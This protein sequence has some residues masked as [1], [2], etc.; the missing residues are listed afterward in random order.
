MSKPTSTRPLYRCAACNK[1]AVRRLGWRCTDCKAKNLP[2]HPIVTTSH[3]K[4]MQQA[5]LSTAKNSV[6]R[7]EKELYY[8]ATSPLE[9]AITTIAEKHGVP[10]DNWEHIIGH[11][12]VREANQLARQLCG[13]P[14][15]RPLTRKMGKHPYV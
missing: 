2:T 8:V 3:Y 6:P 13:I 11:P 5:K 12:F 7:D 9:T 15:E 10:R 14:E 4:R 1:L